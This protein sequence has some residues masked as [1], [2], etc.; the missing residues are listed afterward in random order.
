MSATEERDERERKQFR[1]QVHAA[2]MQ[3]VEDSNAPETLKY[4]SKPEDIESPVEALEWINS[5]STSTTN[6]SEDDVRSKEWVIEYHR[7]MAQQ[8]RPPA[9][10]IVGHRRAFMYDDIDEYKLPL[11]PNKE[12]ETEG[13]SEIG[14]ESSARSKEGWATE[15][16]TADTKESIM[17]DE[18]QEEGGGGILDRIS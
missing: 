11:S 9:Y 14:K 3:G 18:T 10:G 12:L 8:E 16:S 5:R 6:L 17:R 2:N 7:L 4:V 13:Y 1:R 15:T